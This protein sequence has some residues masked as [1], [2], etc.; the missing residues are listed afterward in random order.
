MN[1]MKFAK[2][3]VPSEV[4]KKIELGTFEVQSFNKVS[5]TLPSGS[6]RNVQR[7]Y[8]GSFGKFLADFGKLS[9]KI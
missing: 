9:C 7:T 6:S 3:K 2:V 8:R 5:L 1:R 4:P